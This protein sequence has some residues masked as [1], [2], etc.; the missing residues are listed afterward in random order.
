MTQVRYSPSDF[1][2]PVIGKRTYAKVF[3]EPEWERCAEYIMAQSIFAGYW[4][5]IKVL[6]AEKDL[7]LMIEAGYLENT[8]DGFMLADSALEKLLEKFPAY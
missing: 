5:P 7:S 8:E 1:K 2:A 3:E 6:A 4:K